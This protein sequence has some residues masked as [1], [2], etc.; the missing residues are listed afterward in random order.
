MKNLEICESSVDSDSGSS[1]QSAQPR[2]FS[3]TKTLI[4]LLVASVVVLR[5]LTLGMPG[6]IDTSEGRYGAMG[7][8]MLV[9]GNWLMPYIRLDNGLIPFWGKPPLHFWLTAASLSLFGM[10]EWAA[11]FPSFLGPLFWSTPLFWS[12]FSG[13][14]QL[15]FPPLFWSPLFWSPL[16]W[17]P[18][19]S[20][21]FWSTPTFFPQFFRLN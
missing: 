11:R 4:W 5:L 1:A 7:Q 20:P 21:L 15:F 2:S 17:S 19:W 6:L 14:P 16:F 13:L 12:L 8:D 10:N 3:T 18:L 9:S